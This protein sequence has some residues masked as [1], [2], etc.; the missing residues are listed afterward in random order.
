MFWLGTAARGSRCE[1]PHTAQGASVGHA[2]LIALSLHVQNPALRGTD[3]LRG[4]YPQPS[5]EGL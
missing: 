1:L 4:E 5:D 2:P 3:S